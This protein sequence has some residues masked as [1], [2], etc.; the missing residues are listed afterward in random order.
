MSVSI[1]A[2]STSLSP[3]LSGSS[4]LVCLNTDERMVTCSPSMREMRCDSRIAALLED[5]TL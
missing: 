2:S 3:E 1:K 4:G 5:A